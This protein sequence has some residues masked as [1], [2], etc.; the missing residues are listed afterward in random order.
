MFLLG[1][2]PLLLRESR[3]CV[4][5][6]RAALIPCGSC[7][8]C[9][10][11]TGV[12]NFHL[13]ASWLFCLLPYI[14]SLLLPTCT[15]L[16]LS[17][18]HA[19]L[20]LW[21]D[22]R[23]VASACVCVCLYVCVCVCVIS[24][25]V[26]VCV[27]IRVGGNVHVLRCVFLHGYSA[28]SSANSSHWSDFMKPAWVCCRVRVW[29]WNLTGNCPHGFFCFFWSQQFSPIVKFCFVF[30]QRQEAAARVISCFPVSHSCN[31]N[32]FVQRRHRPTRQRP[33]TPP[34]VIFSELFIPSLCL[35]CGLKMAV[36]M[37]HGFPCDFQNVSNSC[38]ENV[39][40][41]LFVLSQLF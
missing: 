37:I 23:S 15:T 34:P 32:I 22:T 27:S 38:W 40:F 28:L 6:H 25:S 4:S 16:T 19:S 1:N 14:H 21:P 41:V 17:L 3:S 2:K 20:S 36:I 35:W 7:R 10:V 13:S 12:S 11:L 18:S 31:L 5:S 30:I 29:K 33:A 24:I 9:P 39:C 8:L 26:S